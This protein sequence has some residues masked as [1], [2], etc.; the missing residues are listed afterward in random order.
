MTL[1]TW[2]RIC[3]LH[4]GEEAALAAMQR[5][6]IVRKINPKPY[7]PKYLYQDMELSGP[8]A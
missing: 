2:G 5:D 1:Y 3:A 7:G 8:T 4:L 6:E